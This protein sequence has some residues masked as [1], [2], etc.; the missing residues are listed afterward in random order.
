MR[1]VLVNGV[2]DIVHS[3]HIDLLKFAKG[4]GDHLVVAI[5]SDRRVRE[6]K[7]ANRPCND[8]Y[9][10]KIVMESIRYV[11]DVIV[12]DNMEELKKIHLTIRPDFLVKGSD[13]DIDFI[14]S[15]DGVMENTKIVI[16][17]RND[18]RSTTMAIERMKST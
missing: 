2:F 3:G 7:G 15:N 17:P 12:F 13:W 8:Q 14:R 6:T 18:F 10:R 11:D 9:S 1:K 5:D 4:L 16:F